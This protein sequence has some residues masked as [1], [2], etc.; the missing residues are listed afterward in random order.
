MVGEVEAML[1]GQSGH[2]SGGIHP[3][4]C[5]PPSLQLAQGLVG[6]LAGAD[7]LAVESVATAERRDELIADPGES[8]GGVGATAAGAH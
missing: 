5:E 2:L 8:E 3:F 1:A 4:Y 6:G 7:E